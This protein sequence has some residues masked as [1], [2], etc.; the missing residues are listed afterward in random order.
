MIEEN[1]MTEKTG[2]SMPYGKYWGRAAA[3]VPLPYL[4]WFLKSGKAPVPVMD[5]IALRTAPSLLKSLDKELAR[6]DKALAKPTAALF[7]L[8]AKSWELTL[9]L[10]ARLRDAQAQ[11][12]DAERRAQAEGTGEENGREP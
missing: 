7:P 1:T 6:M 12:A 11:V 10:A 4:R 8:G 9:N 3:D 2:H 5:A